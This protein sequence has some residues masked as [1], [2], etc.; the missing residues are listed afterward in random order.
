MKKIEKAFTHLEL[1]SV[2]FLILLLTAIIVPSL[3]K[4]LKNTPVVETD[5]TIESY[6]QSLI[7]Y[8]LL[9]DVNTSLSVHD[10]MGSRGLDAQKCIELKNM[11]EDEMKLYIRRFCLVSER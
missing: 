4:L 9:I 2:I 7:D 8:N 6:Q 10:F 3:V 1:V 5:K 11:P